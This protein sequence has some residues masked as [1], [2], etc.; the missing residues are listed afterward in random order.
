MRLIGFSK[1]SISSGPISPT[2]DGTRGSGIEINGV[3]GKLLLFLCEQIPHVSLVKNRMG[4][5]IK[6]GGKTPDKLRLF[7]QINARGTGLAS[8]GSILLLEIS[9]CDCRWNDP[10]IICFWITATKLPFADIDLQTHGNFIA[11]PP[12][13]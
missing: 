10:L 6:A 5:I 12:L 9:V 8:F 11:M 13:F 1:T 2:M 4:K 3:N 7:A